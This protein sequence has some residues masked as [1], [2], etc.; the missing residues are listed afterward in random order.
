MVLATRDIISLNTISETV[1]LVDKSCVLFDLET[2]I[3]RAIK[4]S[5]DIQWSDK[6]KYFG[7]YVTIYILNI[8]GYFMAFFDFLLASWC[9]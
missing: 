2:E 1:F 7:N 3:L 4:R 6:L 9:L 8:R 5:F